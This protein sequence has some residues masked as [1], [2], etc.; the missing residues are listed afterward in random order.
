MSKNPKQLV[1]MRLLQ[2]YAR[3]LFKAIKKVMNINIKRFCHI[4]QTGCAYTV[5][6]GFIF[7]NLLEFHTNRL[8]KS[9][10]RQAKLP[11]AMADS[12]ADIGI[13]RVNILSQDLVLSHAIKVSGCGHEFRY[14]HTIFYIIRWNWRK[15]KVFRRDVHISGK[16][17]SLHD[18]P[19]R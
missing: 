10:L 8:P 3:K 2:I 13:N 15:E 5:G 7:L 9:L 11:S 18:A 12:L 4:P 17:L 1:Q 16:K 6:A 19:G 14:V